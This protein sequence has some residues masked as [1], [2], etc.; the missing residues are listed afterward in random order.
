MDDEAHL[1]DLDG[2]VGP[3]PMRV[4]RS[5]SRYRLYT[6]AGLASTW[7]GRVSSRANERTKDKSEREGNGPDSL[8]AHLVTLHPE[9]SHNDTRQDVSRV[10]ISRE[11]EREREDGRSG[12][13]CRCATCLRR[14]L[15]GA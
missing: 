4:G 2:Q 12:R 8:G 13:G 10:S 1:R 14:P 7:E 3:N 15:A 5:G 6:S 11:A 9:P